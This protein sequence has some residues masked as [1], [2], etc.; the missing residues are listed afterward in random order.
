MYLCF[1]LERTILEME[2]NR[3]LLGMTLA[4]IGEQ[5]EILKLPKFTAKQIA[6]WVYVKR[7]RTIDEMTNISIRNRDILKKKFE[8]GV[9][10]PIETQVSED[11]TQK[12]LFKTKNDKLIESVLIPDD[13]RLTLCVSSQVGCK[14][15]CDFCMTGKM[16]F[17]DNLSVNEILNQVYSSPNAE[18]ITNVVFMGMGEPLDNYDDVMKAIEIL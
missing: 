18:N 1:K 12:L 5:V 6:D 16:G 8:I 9:S 3:Y 17:H 7:V 10:E 2:Q 13:N 14:M 15:N 4:E 11:G